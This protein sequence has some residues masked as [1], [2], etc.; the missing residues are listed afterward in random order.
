MHY[1]IK[2]FEIK[3]E[4]AAKPYGQASKW[5]LDEI[6]QLPRTSVALDYGCGKFRYTIPLSRRVRTVCAVDSSYQIDRVQQIHDKRT[7][8]EDYA[9]KCL[10][11][12]HV[13]EVSSGTWRKMKFDFVLCV[14]VLSVIPSRQ[15]RIS[16]LRSFR[17][18]LK[19]NGQILVSC[20]Y[21]NSYFDA[22]QNNPNAERHKD[23]W[24][25]RSRNGASFYAIIP[26]ERLL[27]HCR[28]AGLVVLRSGA[29]GETAFAFARP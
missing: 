29:K 23:G 2:G 3:T 19:P 6:A 21:R 15:I 14:N 20:Q 26:P 22:W 8:L 7:T 5:L 17:A 9:D 13:Q 4:N 1:E 16:V 27:R 10:R 24:L 25:V 11:N 28:E 12:V 18:V